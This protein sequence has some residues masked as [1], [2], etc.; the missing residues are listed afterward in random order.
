MVFFHLGTVLPHHMW[1]N[2][3][4][5]GFASFPSQEIQTKGKWNSVDWKGMSHCQ[6]H[7]PSMALHVRHSVQMYNR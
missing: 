7:S 3:G 6:V 5:F 1:I 2:F 4:Y